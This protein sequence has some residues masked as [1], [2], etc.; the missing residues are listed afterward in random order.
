[1]P[2]DV[3]EDTEKIEQGLAD[4]E[5]FL[6]RG[7]DRPFTSLDDKIVITRPMMYAIKIL[8]LIPSFV[9]N[10][11]IP[12][13]IKRFP[14]M[15]AYCFHAAIAENAENLAKQY[16]NECGIDINIEYDKTQSTDLTSQTSTRI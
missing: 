9:E 10:P 7:L 1:M 8:R 4:T 2:C 15:K 5:A 13:L 12:V 14:A 6:C 3:M 16:L 11:D